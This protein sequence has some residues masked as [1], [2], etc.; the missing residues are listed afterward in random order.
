MYNTHNNV[1]D[2]SSIFVFG[3]NLAGRH[4]AGAAKFAVKHCGAKYGVGEG[5]QGNS[6]AIP[7]KNE[8]LCVLPLHTIESFVEQFVEFSLLKVGCGEKFFVT[9][10]GCGLAGYSP[11]DIAPMFKY[12]ESNCI[13]PIEF[14]K[15]LGSDITH[16]Y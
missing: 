14:A 2:G 12:V 3:S 8:K 7:T 10:V 1:W 15:V 6:Y 16:S 11:E 13:I 5:I 9:Q 4:G